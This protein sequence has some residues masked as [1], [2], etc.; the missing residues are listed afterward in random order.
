MGQQPVNTQPQQRRS[1]N[2]EEVSLGYSKKQAI[3]ESRRC[4]QCAVPVCSYAC[5]LGIDIPGFIRAIREGEPNRA[6][7]KIKEHNM[8]ASICGRLCPAPCE[9]ACVFEAE[10]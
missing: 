7:A 6:L 1:R 5:P 10:Q 8:L 3:D 2:F 9:K 4:I